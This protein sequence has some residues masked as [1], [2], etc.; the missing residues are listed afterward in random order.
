MYYIK[1][2]VPQRLGLSGFL[3]ALVLADLFEVLVN[4]FFEGASDFLAMGIG[5]EQIGFFFIRHETS[6]DQNGWNVR[7]FENGKSSGT[8]RA[9][10]GFDLVLIEAF[11]QRVGEE[12]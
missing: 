1:S 3:Y 7:G 8:V 4:A 9:G 11:D 2:V 10:Q 12:F 5:I 6:F